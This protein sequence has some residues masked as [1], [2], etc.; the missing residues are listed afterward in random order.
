MIYFSFWPIWFANHPGSP[1]CYFLCFW[2]QTRRQIYISEQ[3]Q[4]W[5]WHLQEAV[6]WQ[7]V[8]LSHIGSM[9]MVYLHEWVGK[10]IY[11][12]WMTRVLYKTDFKLRWCHSGRE[13]NM[14]LH[15]Y[16]IYTYTFMTLLRCVVFFTGIF[17]GLLQWISH[18][19]D[20]CRVWMT[21]ENWTCFDELSS[22]FHEWSVTQFKRRIKNIWISSCRDKFWRIFLTWEIYMGVSKNKGKTPK[23]MV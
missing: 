13:A 2:R 14:F 23:W 15:V 4:S 9:R 1:R 11:H 5:Q 20:G 3:L 22:T 6:H 16:H 10:Y 18:S 19:L 8:F 7:H 17:V 12:T 21:V